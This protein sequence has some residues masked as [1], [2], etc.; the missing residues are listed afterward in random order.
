MLPAKIVWLPAAKGKDAEK[1]CLQIR[2]KT[3][4]NKFKTLFFFTSDLNLLHA[5]K[6]R[7]KIASTE[8]ISQNISKVMNQLDLVFTISIY[9]NFHKLML[10]K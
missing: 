10:E 6:S 3:K 9:N 8:V 7:I 4:E 1:Y 5:L 2:L